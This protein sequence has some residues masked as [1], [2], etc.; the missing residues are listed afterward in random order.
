MIAP[1]LQYNLS[2]MAATLRAY[3]EAS[4]KTEQEI[5]SKKGRDLAFKVYTGLRKLAPAKGSIRDTQL[6]ALKSGRGVH[7]RPAVMADIAGKYGAVTSVATGKT[8]LNLT[9]GK[10]GRGKVLAMAGGIWRDGKRLNLEALAVERELAIRESG[11]G[12]S[13]IAVPRPSS[14]SA[15]TL[16]RDIESRYG[17]TLSEY[18]LDLNAESKFALMRWVGRQND[19]YSDAV[20]GLEKAKQ[21]TVLNEAVKATTEDTLEYVKRKLG[22]DIGRF[23]L[24]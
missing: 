24:S 13:S 11:R 17:F 8:Y 9:T 12:F 18:K 1:E 23:G 19:L 15:E 6:A 10:N 22:E 4:G 7:V 5:V 20:S 21:K 16:V 14:A 3:A 2:R